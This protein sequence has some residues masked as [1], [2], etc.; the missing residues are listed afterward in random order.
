MHVYVFE[1]VYRY[2]GI[3]L[4]I[5]TIYAIRLIYKVT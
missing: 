4:S 1:H 3:Y 5:Y 2:V